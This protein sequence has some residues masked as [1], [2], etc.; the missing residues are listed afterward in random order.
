MIRKV[1]SSYR[2]T[3]EDVRKFVLE[4]YGIDATVRQLVSEMD[5]NFH[6]KDETGKEYIFKVANPSRRKEVL[7]LQNKALDFLSKNN[8][9]I[10][11]PQVCKTLAG[12]Q[13]TFIENDKGRRFYAWMLTYIRGRFLAE[14]D[15]P[16]SKLLH[17]LGRFIGS[18]DKTLVRFHHPA[19]HRELP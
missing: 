1:S 4:L 17:Q 10:R 12:K 11:C 3:E 19:A 16:S 7:D 5:Q 9:T 2:F 15:R 8:N 13:I 18:L 14:I 6:L